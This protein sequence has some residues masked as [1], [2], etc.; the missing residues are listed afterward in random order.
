MTIRVLVE[1]PS[2]A[3][4]RLPVF[5]ELA[6]R[7]GLDFTLCYSQAPTLPNVEPDG[8]NARF[9]PSW[10]GTVAGRRIIWNGSCWANARRGAADVLILNWNLNHLNL[11]P[12]L[13]RARA[14]GVG[15]ILW[16][17]GYSKAE[18]RWRRLGRH[19]AARLANALLF[20]NFSTARQ[21]MEQGWPKERI[22]VALNALDQRPIQAARRAWMAEPGRLGAFR[23][24][25]GIGEG[26]V[27][28][29]VSRI[30]PE[31]RLD[32]LIRAT[33]LLRK[34]HPLLQTV[35]VGTGAE[36]DE[37]KTLAAR[38]GAGEAVR[39]LGAV[40]DEMALAPWFL[41]ADAFCYPANI[42]LSLL[43]AFGY[44]LPVIT[45]DR[46]ELQNPEIEA[47]EPG[48]NGLVYKHD[49]LEALA[50]TLERVI[51]DRPLRESL[52]AEALVT[53]TQR[54]NL[55]TMVDGIEQAIRYAAAAVRSDEVVAANPG[56]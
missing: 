37:L 56:E 15:T 2:L 18:A 11:V 33:A 27:L 34:R 46:N 31:N 38:E 14:N 43:H 26:P 5:Q 4:Y 53:A 35:V 8:F 16:G 13:L 6:R 10:R 17:H 40:Y 36:L 30:K 20:Y 21:F 3:K 32:L 42:G 12:A 9:V 23:K 28:L 55:R 45:T 29:Y 24:E 49:D 19:G 50:S 41:S 51:V 39:F 25:Q 44:G 47:L 22:Y 54:F 1:Q 7:P 52:A 48:R